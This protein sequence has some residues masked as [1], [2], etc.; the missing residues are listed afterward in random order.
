MT[1]RRTQSSVMRGDEWKEEMTPLYGGGWVLVNSRNY[2]SLVSGESP[3]KYFFV[4]GRKLAPLHTTAQ[5][6]I[7]LDIIIQVT[8]KGG[9]T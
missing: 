2:T 4:T 1:I 7:H 8:T 3:G 5:H 6:Y 9:R